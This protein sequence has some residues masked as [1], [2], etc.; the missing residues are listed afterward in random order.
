MEIQHALML[1]IVITAVILFSLETISIDIIALGVLLSLILTGLLP[2]DKAFTGFGNE[3]II[4]IVGLLILT[5]SLIRNGV[6]ELISRKLISGRANNPQRLLVYL[7]AVIAATSSFIS[8]TAAT[9]LFLP[10]G[11][12]VAR[13][14]R[15]SISK[16]L[17]PVAFAAILASSVTLVASSTNIVVGGILKQYGLPSLGLFELTP[18]GLPIAVVG[19]IYMAVIGIRLIPQRETPKSLT[20][21][22]GLRP[23]LS[24]IVI[25]PSSSLVGKTLQEADLTN[26]L[27]LT[28]IALFRQ[29][30][31]LPELN[32]DTVLQSGDV[33]LV[34]G[35]RDQLL[36]IKD[37]I[38]LD[39]LPES[40]VPENQMQGL[41]QRL[42]EAIILPRSYLIGR[43]LRGS[44]LR[45]RY[46]INVLA[47]NRQE[48]TLTQK[49]NQ[50]PLR[51]G[52]VLLLQGEEQDVT[53]LENNF[54][55]RI[56]NQVE[57]KKVDTRRTRI[58]IGIFLG[59]LLLAASGWVSL[60][61]AILGGVV[62]ALLTR[63]ITPEE[64]YREVEWKIVIL[65][66]SML[67][68]GIAMDQSGTAKFLAQQLAQWVGGA[69]PLWLLSGFFL[70]SLLL[71]QPMSNQ[72]A[73]AVVL[74]VAIQT[75]LHL[76]L[77]PRTFAIM[78]AIGASTSF[79]TPLEPACLMVYGLGHYRF[80]D[81]V[82]VGSLLTVAIYLI[83]ILLVPW[84]WPLR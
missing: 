17:M 3:T 51:L 79:I 70:L 38:G 54:M 26:T 2:P 71:T 64:A 41:E 56:L 7:M 31:R 73:A 83:A 15:T 9:A 28:I 69:H 35:S 45:S 19:L 4:I 55:Y 76:G 60:P 77:N 21:E 5:A 58:A 53:T 30:R 47:I 66:G 44:N 25:L 1:L 48:E 84:F 36:Q 43:T 22:F 12:A 13:K 16:V 72:A 65:I 23:Y 42:Y 46:R 8:N 33:L 61:V 52:D 6:I 75:A 57:E 68:L 37:T 50:I 80:F 63:C 18:V 74:P 39:L 14:T 59:V 11:N 49:L 78:I 10:I 81:F 29:Q 24:E 40:T 82:K 34:E 67:G 27:D 20:D 32:A 62:L